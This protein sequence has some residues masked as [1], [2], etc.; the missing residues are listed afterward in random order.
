MRPLCGGRVLVLRVPSWAQ[1]GTTAGLWPCFTGSLLAPPAQ[2]QAV[3]LPGP[4]SSPRNTILASTISQC[5][6]GV[7]PAS[8]HIHCGF[9][10]PAISLLVSLPGPHLISAAGDLESF[11]NSRVGARARH[12]PCPILENANF[13]T[14]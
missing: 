2:T 4:L 10:P 5:P 8:L 13:E 3:A 12:K 9:S 6:G 11:L 14:R 7:S 1:P